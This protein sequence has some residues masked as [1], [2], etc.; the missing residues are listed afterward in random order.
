MRANQDFRDMETSIERCVDVLVIGAGMAG[1][2]AAGAL[3]EAGRKVVV[4]DKGRG[5][6]GRLATRRFG[7]ATFDHGAQFVTARSARFAEVLEKARA[8][9]AA[10]EWCR[11]FLGKRD[12]HLRWCGCG[13]MTALARHM[14]VGLEV[15]SEKQVR[16]LQQSGGAWRVALADGSH[17]L[18]GAV[19]VT[20]PVPQALELLAQ[21]GVGLLPEMER[22]LSAIEYECCLAVL[23]VLDGPS[24]WPA[25]GAFALE[26]GPVAWMADNQVKGISAEP[27]ITLHATPEFSLAHWDQ[28]RRQSGQE[29][30]DAVRP[31]LGAGVK[32]FQVHGWRFSKPMEA[33]R[34]AC[35]VVRR[36]PFLAV[37]GDAFAGSR[38]EGA[39]LSGWAAAAEALGE[40]AWG[41]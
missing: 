32:D 8:A 7:G 17:W 41:A 9:G 1:L 5:V 13:G 36:D 4:V 27:A 37:A 35:A 16:A 20:A 6:G 2:A 24:G 15:V 28:D 21:G 14:A 11:G 38:V 40:A 18:A 34:E 22:R 23:A 10:R 33:G 12:G 3:Q 30:L 26:G 19:V 25:P 31:R 39:A 29:L